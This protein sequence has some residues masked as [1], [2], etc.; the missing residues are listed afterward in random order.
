MGRAAAVCCCGRL[1]MRSAAAAM[2]AAVARTVACPDCSSYLCCWCCGCACPSCVCCGLVVRS[3]GGVRR[4]FETCRC[5]IRKS[6]RKWS[7]GR[8]GCP[9]LAAGPWSWAQGNVVGGD[10]R[11]GERG[12]GKWGCGEISWNGGGGV[13]VSGGAV[14]GRNGIR[15]SG[16][17]VGCQWESGWSRKRLRES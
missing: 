6:A 7:R 12:R 1:R 15:G 2:T 9:E 3:S 10:L 11:R 14:C 17:G 8:R 13:R 5:P 16:A 4:T